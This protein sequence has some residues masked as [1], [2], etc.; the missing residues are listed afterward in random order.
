MMQLTCPCCH[1]H[2]PLES[3]MQDDAGREL[4]SVLLALHPD[5]ARAL[6]HYLS[7]F[8]PLKQQ[9][10]WG[11]ALRLCREVQALT[12]DAG[13]LQAGLVETARTLGERRQAPGWKPLGNHN[14]LRRC[15]ETVEAAAVA[16]VAPTAA[17]PR[18][19]AGAGLVALEALKR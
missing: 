9:L 19:R 7:F 15:L 10:G 3:A 17:A 14:Y 6:V 13:R 8:R 4:V 16:P 18:S 2:I 12:S 1:A 5:L 11:R